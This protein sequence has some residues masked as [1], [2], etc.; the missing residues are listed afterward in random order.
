MP[1][2]RLRPARVIETYS[3][4]IKLAQVARGDADLYVCDYDRLHDWDLAAGHILVEEAGGRVTDM[5][6]G[7][8]TYGRQPPVHERGIIATNGALHDAALAELRQRL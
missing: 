7:Q 1:V 4:G 8:L 3:A 2:Q 5:D 6:G